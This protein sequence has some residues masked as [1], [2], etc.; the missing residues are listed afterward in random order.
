MK[1]IRDEDTERNNGLADAAGLAAEVLG[2]EMG[3]GSKGR[4]PEYGKYGINGQHGVDLGELAGAVKS[5]GHDEV[6]PCRD[7]EEAL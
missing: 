1:H 3:L 2:V 4:E 6:D 5:G 7:G